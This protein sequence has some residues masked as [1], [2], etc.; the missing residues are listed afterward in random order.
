[1]LYRIV[2][3]GLPIAY[4]PRLTVFHQHRREYR[5]LRHQMYTWGLGIVTYAVKNYRADPT[6][7]KSF[8]CMILGWFRTIAALAVKST[9]KNHPWEPDLALAEL[10]GGVVGL[11]GEYDR[12]RRRIAQIRKRFPA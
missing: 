10:W 11:F 9:R 7:R 3:A 12:S 2:R 8:R 5:A 1:M 6:Q 4:E